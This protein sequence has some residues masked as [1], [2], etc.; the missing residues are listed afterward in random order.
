MFTPDFADLLEFLSAAEP[1][2]WQQILTGCSR[3]LDIAEAVCEAGSFVT[4]C[5]TLAAIFNSVI[6]RIA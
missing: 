1:S 6:I 4:V 2:S 3:I 5:F